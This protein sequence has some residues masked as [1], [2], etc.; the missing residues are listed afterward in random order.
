MQVVRLKGVGASLAPMLLR[1][2]KEHT[3]PQSS[4][5]EWASLASSGQHHQALGKPCTNTVLTLSRVKGMRG[6]AL[7]L[8]N[9][10]D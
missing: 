2:A 4:Y 7:V 9:K 8:R 1:E 10:A 5:I 3:C 6:T